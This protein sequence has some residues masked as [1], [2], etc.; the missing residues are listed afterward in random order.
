MSHVLTAIAKRS[1]LSATDNENVLS[2]LKN[3]PIKVVS[4]KVLSPSKAIDYIVDLTTTE[5]DINSLLKKDENSLPNVDIVFQ[6]N[7]EHRKDKKLIVFDMDSTLIQ[8]EVIEL[9]A[10]QAGVE[11][12]VADITTRAMNGEL[13]FKQSLAERVALLRGIKSQ[14]LWDDLKPQLSLTPGTKE[15]CSFMKKQGCKLAVCSGGFLPLAEFVKE[16]LGLDY[17]FANLLETEVDVDGVEILSGKTIGEVVDGQRKKNLLLQLA[18]ENKVPLQKT[19][20]VGDG[21]NDLPMMGQAGYGIAWNAKPKVQKEAPCYQETFLREKK[22]A[23]ELAVKLEENAQLGKG[24]KNGHVKK[25]E[26]TIY[27]TDTKLI[28][29]KFNEWDYYS[30]KIKLPIYARG[31][32]TTVD[33]EIICRGY[34]KFFNMN[35]MSSVKEDELRKHTSG[36]YTVTVKSNGCIIFISGLPSGQL[37]VCSKHSTGEHDDLSKNHALVAQNA[38]EKQLKRMNVDIEQLAKLLYD[39][40]ITAVCE[41]CNDE[42]EEHVLEYKDDKAGLYLHGLNFNTVEFKTYPIEEVQLFGE[43]YGFKKTDY[44]KFDKFDDALRFMNESNETGTFNGEEVEGYVIRCFRNG[45]DFFFKYK[46]EEPYFLYRELREITKQF[47]KNGPENLKFGK[48]KLICMDYIKFVMPYLISDDKLK[49]DYLENKGIISLRKMYFESKKA[50]SMQLIKEEL[51]MIDLEDEMKKL[52][53]GESKSCRYVFITV[54]TIGCGKTTTSVGLMN[55]FPE[56]V[57]HVQNDNIQSPG[58]DGLVSAALDVLTKKPIVVVDKNNH[59]FVERQHLFDGFRKLNT[60]IPKDKLKFICLNFVS[61]PKKD[62][63]LWNLTKE[64]VIARGDDHQSIKVNKD[65]VDKAVM[66]MKGFI[67]RFQPIT[68]AKSPDSEFDYIIDL[69]VHEKDSSLQ[70]LKL[71]VAKMREL[72]KDVELPQ[73]TE[74]D[75]LKAFEKAKQ[76]KPTFNKS[77]KPFSKRKLSYIGLSVDNRCLDTIKS[78][79]IDFFHRLEQL[80]RV[81]EGFH[82]TLVHNAMRRGNEEKKKL[83]ETYKQVFKDEIAKFVSFDVEL[84][85]NQKCMFSDQY[86]ADVKLTRIVWNTQAMCIETEITGFF[87]NGEPMDLSCGNMYPHITIGTIDK[88]IAPV[89]AGQILQNYHEGK[90]TDSINIITLDEPVVLQKLPFYSFMM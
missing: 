73:L 36:P 52:K 89:V 22:N 10:A 5:S 85:P 80:G 77:V 90:K 69:D 70:N 76:Y 45:S 40:K 63:N 50:T 18:E 23:K 14:S 33:G 30:K 65:G 17:A 66:I 43:K 47:I 2:L 57:G 4:S 88:S 46:F 42:F 68:P 75:Y 81:Q 51:Q 20:A 54:A 25:I 86:W 58:K 35:E 7:D 19:V 1:P 26:N 83:W 87:H 12:K 16:Q 53:F 38:I 13:D 71:I 41:F 44:V 61:N 24:S 34:D 82:I 27:N 62:E 48:H 31:L 6:K 49:D 32:F 74:D 78:K 11:D 67:N 21:A 8:Q 3:L 28:S 59:K 79:N 60:D 37:V 56:L 55:L 39:N 84:P 15:L 72:I 9:I 64:R 29:W